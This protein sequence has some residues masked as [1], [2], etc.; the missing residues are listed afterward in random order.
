MSNPDQSPATDAALPSDRINDICDL[1]VRLIREKRASH[2][3][4][5]I[6]AGADYYIGDV[7][8]YVAHAVNEAAASRI[9]E[10]VA[11]NE[12]LSKS[13]D[14]SL[15]CNVQGI[16]ESLASA[17]PVDPTEAAA[18]AATAPA[19]YVLLPRRP[20]REMERIFEEEGWQWEHILE[21]V[22]DITPDLPEDI[23]AIIA[24]LGD[25]AAALRA[26]NPECERAANMDAAAALIERLAPQ[27]PVAD[28]PA[29]PS[30]ADPIR[31]LLQAHEDLIEQ[32][33]NYAYFELAYT[34][35][36]G[37][38]AW[39]TDRPASGEPGTA[40][41]AKSRNVIAQGQGDSAEEACQDALDVMRAPKGDSNG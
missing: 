9:A 16:A 23:E 5:G 35:R 12:M 41:Y 2:I 40:E 39:L 20:T 38:M 21:A 6:D 1:Y 29:E 8:G 26:E 31:G 10:L 15:F 7:A 28:Q 11:E 17:Q 22:G 13:L 4:K 36:T 32:G 33:E 25:D 19:G 3:D 27:A 30:P 24:C 14:E 37:W 34:R 18:M